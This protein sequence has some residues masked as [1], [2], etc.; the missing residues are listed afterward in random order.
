M[1]STWQLKKKIGMFLRHL[2]LIALVGGIVAGCRTPGNQ[3]P[4][5]TGNQ[6][7]SVMDSDV[8]PTEIVEFKYP[9]GKIHKRAEAYKDADG[10]LI[11]HGET[12]T[13]YE[14]GE[15]Q[16]LMT[17]VAGV[18]HGPR[19]AWYRNGKIRSQGQFVN[20]RE[21]G[22]WFVWYPNGQKAE[23]RHYANGAYHGTFVAWHMSGKK[24]SQGNWTNGKRQGVHVTWDE[25]GDVFQRT[26]YVDGVP[27]P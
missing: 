19:I 9:D 15:K 22:T 21:D 5:A 3:V 12:R 8:P 10:D 17:F 25:A 27:Q 6:K 11:S 16:S 24:K 2:P 23:E 26:E 4:V 13:F 14:S 7:P 20:G 1:R 18:R